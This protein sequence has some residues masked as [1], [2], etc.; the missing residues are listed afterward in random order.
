LNAT[1]PNLS[2]DLH[3]CRFRGWLVGPDSEIPAEPHERCAR[4]LLE[5]I[6]CNHLVCGR[7]GA[8]VRD[9]VGLLAHGGTPAQRAAARAAA[10]AALGGAG[11]AGL[12]SGTE[13]ALRF[14]H[15]LCRCDDEAIEAPMHLE[16]PC[17]TS[18]GL[19][20]R[21][22][23]WACA[24][25]PARRIPFTHCGLLID[26]G[27][28]FDALVDR[29]LRGWVPEGARPAERLRPQ[30]WLHR[31]HTHLLGTTLEDRVARAMARFVDGDDPAL[32]R[33]A[34]R[35]YQSFPAAAGYDRV[36][37]LWD[38]GREGILRESAPADPP[39]EPLAMAAF[40]AL[41]A[42]VE[43]GVAEATARV[44]A[45]LGKPLDDLVPHAAK[46]ARGRKRAKGARRPVNH[47]AAVEHL[48]GRILRLLAGRDAA[49][50]AD[51]AV[52]VAEA[53]A[54]SRAVRTPFDVAHTI[55]VMDDTR[56]DEVV[57][58][59]VSAGLATPARAAEFVRS[60]MGG[61]PGRDALLG[62]LDEGRPAISFEGARITL[63]SVEEVVCE[64]VLRGA[65]TRRDDRTW[66]DW[67]RGAHDACAA[68]P[69]LQAALSR[70]LGGWV[71][72][73]GETTSLV[74]RFFG[75]RRG[76][77]GGEAVVQE[78]VERL[79]RYPIGAPDPIE[80]GVA[81]TLRCALVKAAAGWAEPL[82]ERL[83]DVLR[84]EVRTPDGAF[85]LTGLLWR[86]DR[87]WAEAHEAEILAAQPG[88]AY[89]I[90]LERKTAGA[91]PAATLEGLLS[92]VTRADVGPL[93]YAVR[94]DVADPAVAR[95]LLAKIRSLPPL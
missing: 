31:L 20:Y 18:E 43:Q 22:P 4:G 44:R 92:R 83:R 59:L 81:R 46:P 7:C 62:R 8:R 58:A 32:L 48:G 73:G 77:P 54:R 65:Y 88:A 82:P 11:A 16:E 36:L 10:Y 15:Y 76:I 74:A 30:A 68:V 49:W 42:G 89:P 39:G 87:A 45:L 34:L 17:T 23:P 61:H 53:A 56:L 93:E 35:F 28:G 2:A 57:P 67:I 90:Y 75:D 78:A 47:K 29:V 41:A 3:F 40:E 91:D 1:E 37:S 94:R 95:R 27:T 69:A 33:A 70:A 86:R 21:T 66:L 25:H 6:G 26:E 80:G 84:R 24:G 79:D 63:E 72:A 14:R 13:Q 19:E 50:V 55:S 64:Q 85:A 51:N 52:G 9:G 5:P 12:A 38:R 60:C 71:G